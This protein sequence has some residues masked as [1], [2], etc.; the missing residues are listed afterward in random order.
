[1]VGL[2]NHKYTSTHKKIITKEIYGGH[3][4]YI[5][6]AMGNVPV[7]VTMETESSTATNCVVE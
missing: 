3:N 1:M 7:V 6:T 4:S 5:V 2:T